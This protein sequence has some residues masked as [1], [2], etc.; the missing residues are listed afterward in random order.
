LVQNAIEAVAGRGDARVTLIAVAGN[1]AVELTV[2]DN[3]PG[4]DPAIAASLFTPFATAKP[5][6]L[7]LGLAIARDIARDLGGD[8]VHRPS[9]SGATF[10]ARLK[11]A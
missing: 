8:I 11:T 10:V 9:A 6:G 1:G 7:G 3:G 5:D 2:A 4:L